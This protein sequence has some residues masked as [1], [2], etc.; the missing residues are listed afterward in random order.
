M[1][2][3]NATIATVSP[4]RTSARNVRLSYP[5]RS[6]LKSFGVKDRIVTLGSLITGTGGFIA[7][8]QDRIH[9]ASGLAT[10]CLTKPNAASGSFTRR[11]LA[12]QFEAIA[13]QRSDNLDQRIDDAA[14]LPVG[15]LHPLDGW[16]RAAALPANR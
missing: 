15:S 9:P 1:A 12:D 8:E 14:N 11:M 5:S 2:S 4:A 6:V 10:G 16:H 3:G 7:I 13:F